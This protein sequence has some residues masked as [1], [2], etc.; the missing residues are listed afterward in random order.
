MEALVRS[1][2]MRELLFGEFFLLVLFPI[3]F[4]VR[5]RNFVIAARIEIDINPRFY[6]KHYILPGRYFRKFFVLPRKE[7]PRFL[8]VDLWSALLFSAQ[9]FVGAIWG[10]ITGNTIVLYYFM[11][12]IAVEAGIARIVILVLTVIYKKV[13]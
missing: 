13:K 9:G 7:I 2:E 8:Y 3:F 6:P 12:V 1:Y 10:G 5:C 11:A 4:Y